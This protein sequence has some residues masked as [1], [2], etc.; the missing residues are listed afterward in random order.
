MQGVTSERLRS[1]E[2]HT[3]IYR[4]RLIIIL[5]ISQKSRTH[6]CRGALT[7][8]RERQSDISQTT[9]VPTTPFVWWSQTKQNYYKL[10]IKFVGFF[11]DFYYILEFRYRTNCWLLK[12]LCSRKELVI[13]LF[14]CSTWICSLQDF[15]DMYHVSRVF[16]A[17]LPPLLLIITLF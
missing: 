17:K 3:F 9:V 10:I 2:P 13:F 5:Y 6:A 12:P 15:Q 1:S 8:V 11:W 7:P 16:I 14:H 4:V